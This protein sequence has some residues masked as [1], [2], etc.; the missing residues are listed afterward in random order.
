MMQV[1][2]KAHVKCWARVAQWQGYARSIVVE[3]RSAACESRVDGG[4]REALTD[5]GTCVYWLSPLAR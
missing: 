1:M 5:G 4:G 3:G 2:G